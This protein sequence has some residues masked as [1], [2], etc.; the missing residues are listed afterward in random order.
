MTLQ[1]Y[2]MLN[3]CIGWL[4]GAVDSVKPRLNNDWDIY[5]SHRWFASLDMMSLYARVDGLICLR[6]RA[7]YRF[8][9]RV[10]ESRTTQM[11]DYLPYPFIQCWIM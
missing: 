8:S 10:K 2:S 6:H 9:P 11:I 1:S 5:S 3:G 7:T 4:Y